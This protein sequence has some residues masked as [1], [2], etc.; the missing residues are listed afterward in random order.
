MNAADIERLRDGIQ[1]LRGAIHHAGLRQTVPD[2]DAGRVQAYLDESL[3]TLRQATVQ[4]TVIIPGKDGDLWALELHQ[5][6][7]RV[8]RLVLAMLWGHT[9]QAESEA[10]ESYL[11]RCEDELYALRDFA[12][13]NMGG[14]G[15]AEGDGDQSGRRRE[16]NPAVSDFS[17]AESALETLLQT[18]KTYGENPHPVQEDFDGLEEK[19]KIAN[20]CLFAAFSDDAYRHLP[21]LEGACPARFVRKKGKREAYK[22]YVDEK[23]RVWVPLKDCQDAWTEKVNRILKKVIEERAKALMRLAGTETAEGEAAGDQSRTKSVEVQTSAPGRGKGDD[24]DREP[25]KTEQAEGADDQVDQG[26]TKP[27]EVIA[28]PGKEKAETDGEDGDK[29]KLDTIPQVVLDIIKKQPK[30]KGIQGK[31]II[32]KLKRKGITLAES[33]LR[34][35]TLPQLKGYGVI[36]IKAAGGYLIPHSDT[37]SDGTQEP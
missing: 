6:C 27:A 26:E 33:T 8:R 18:W 12:A 31:A 22:P 4:G 35:H 30:G 11:Q 24:I 36:N 10:L 16:S 23:G 9:D 19:V 34:R 17:R 29:P 5:K 25:G 1:G 14:T 15:Q 21:L 7:E 28:G 13:A 32:S 20:A 3:K 37:C 2:V